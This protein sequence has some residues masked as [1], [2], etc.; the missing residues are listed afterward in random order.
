MKRVLVAVDEAEASERTA[1]FVND[2]FSGP[3]IEILAISVTTT[4]ITW[5][6]GPAGT[7]W[8]SPWLWPI[9]TP[10]D[11]R[12]QRVLQQSDVNQDASI[13]EA[14][15]P[16]EVICAVARERDVDLIVVGSHHKGLLERLLSGSVSRDVLHHADR[17]VLI[18]P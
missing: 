14:G 5:L 10:D 11:A 18:V 1:R 17:P 9:G 16:A 2:F 3:D 15:D 7:G 6:A 4:P 13:V 8:T 12:A